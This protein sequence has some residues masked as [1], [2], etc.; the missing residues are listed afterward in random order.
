M[1]FSTGGHSR[2]LFAL[3]KVA[4]T[5]DGGDLE[6]FVIL[7]AVVLDVI[8]TPLFDDSHPASGKV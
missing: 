7:I 2:Y 5:L 8:E 1:S 4:H 6:L 3:D